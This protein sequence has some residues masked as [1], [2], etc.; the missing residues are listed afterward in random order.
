MTAGMVAIGAGPM[1]SAQGS[2]A[3]A[4]RMPAQIATMGAPATQATAGVRPE[5]SS[6][7]LGTQVIDG[8]LVEGTRRIATY[9]AGSMGNDRPI[10]TT[11]ETWNSPELKAMV[12]SKSYDPRSGESITRLTNISRAEPD[13]GLFRVPP[14]YQ[15]IQETGPYTIKISRP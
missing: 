15:V 7:A 14:G 10:V 5:F 2:A 11:S 6:E 1:G 9:P 12:L 4:A 3:A 8:I 13:P